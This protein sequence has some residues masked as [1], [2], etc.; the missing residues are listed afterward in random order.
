[1]LNAERSLCFKPNLDTRSKT[2]KSRNGNEINA[3]IVDAKDSYQILNEI[4]KHLNTLEYTVSTFPDHVFISEVQFFD[5][6]IIDVLLKL[7][8]QG[9]KVIVEGLL[10]DFKGQMFGYAH[11]ISR[12]CDEYLWVDMDCECCFIDKAVFNYRLIQN[13]SQVLIG[14]SEA[15]RGLC[16]SCYDENIKLENEVA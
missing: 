2:I 9:Y 14:G 16:K 13:N 12:I 1:M 3:I 15:Y 5:K 11:E 7:K 6:S 8:N 10:T 4:I